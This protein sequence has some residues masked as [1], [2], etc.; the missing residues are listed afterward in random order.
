ML[1]EEADIPN[2]VGEGVGRTV[3]EDTFAQLKQL[4]PE[5][6]A[7]FMGL[8]GQL[9][10][11]DLALRVTPTSPNDEDPDRVMGAAPARRRRADP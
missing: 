1:V 2:F 6:R 7:R 10:D 3:I 11:D 9:S 5:E 8:L 4:S